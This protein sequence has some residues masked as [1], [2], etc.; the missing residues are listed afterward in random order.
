[1]ETFTSGGG[2]DKYFEEDRVAFYA[3]GRI[4]GEWLLTLAYDSKK[5]DNTDQ[6]GLYQTID[7]NKF[8]TLYGDGTL[9]GNDA[10]SARHI[11]VKL[12]RD[13]FYAL[14]GD[15]NAGLS[16]TELSRY[17][18]NFTGFK[19]EMKTKDYEYT[20]FLADTN[21]AHVRDEF[22]GDGTSGLYH[23]SRKNIVL[24]SET[25]TI[26]TR[27][28][29]KSEV[30]LS[31]Q[32]LTSHLDYTIDYESGTIFFKMPVYS[33]DGNF[34][35]IFIVAEYESFDDSDTKY[36][37]GGR[38]A[39]RFLDSRVEV[40]ASH[41]HEGQVGGSGNLEGVDAKVKLGE[42]DTLRAEAATTKTD[43]DGVTSKGD[44]YL[45]ELQHRS[46][47]VEGKAYV[48]E[49]QVGFGLGQQNASETGTRKV[50]ADLN[51]RINKPLTVGGEVFQQNNLSTGAVRDMA[52]VRG[53]YTTGRY[54]LTAG[55]RRAKDTL[56]T[57][58]TQSFGETQR[59]DQLFTGVK[60]QVTD[61]TAVRISHDQSIGANNNVDF[62]TRTTVG[63]DYKLNEKSTLF[64]DQEWTDGSA[65]NTATTR[66]GIRTSPWTGGQIGSSLEQQSTENGVRLFSTTGLKQSWQVTKQ[67]SVDGGLDRSQTL[68]NTGT[69]SVN[70]NVP[71]A[72]G[73]SEDFTAVSLGAGY[74]Q[75]KWSWTGAGREA[76][77]GFGGQVRPVHGRQR[78][79]A[80]RARARGR[81]ANVQDR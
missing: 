57:A 11:Y 28:R 38:V 59:S 5:R 64:A 60:A 47:T 16:I 9:Q 67:W 22:P 53:N 33:R 65:I 70:T 32:R 7:P 15:F 37:Y 81:T 6:P 1:M 76:H 12:E 3:K 56:S 69:Y 68:R 63:A 72:S 10:A 31:S 75:E 46:E 27:D 74:R 48:R 77:F 36:N 40:G 66:L 4:K 71:P 45:A 18:R 61:K 8:Y 29:F 73:S 34:N 80:E 23:L 13:Q 55:L 43:Q 19:S 39:A 51:Y 14:F 41:V 62:P 54:T 20:V 50:G 26:E 42:H 21:Q 79:S 2:D 24:N 49:Q 44:A 35:P 25:I 17:N 52:E 30:I 78:R 58:E